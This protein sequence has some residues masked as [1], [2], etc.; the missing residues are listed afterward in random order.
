M[1]F[2]ANNSG[3][4]RKS[5]IE[6]DDGHKEH[7]SLKF[8]REIKNNCEF[9]TKGLEG[10]GSANEPKLERQMFI[11]I[12]E[13]GLESGSLEMTKLSIHI[14]GDTF[15]KIGQN[16]VFDQSGREA[17]DAPNSRNFKLLKVT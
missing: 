7:F 2:F 12:V 3:P 8:M 11:E 9:L 6:T 14:L 17:N 16:H 1:P 4:L 15:M 13:A 10:Q 5:I